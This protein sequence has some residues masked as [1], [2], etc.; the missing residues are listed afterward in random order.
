MFMFLMFIDGDWWT[1]LGRMNTKIA[2][3]NEMQAMSRP[4][5]RPIKLFTARE[6]ITCHALLIG[7]AMYIQ[8]GVNLWS[9]PNDTINGAPDVDEAWT[10]ILQGPNFDQYGVHCYR[11]KQ[12]KRFVPRMWESEELRVGQDRWWKFAEAINSFNE[13]RSENIMTSSN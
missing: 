6:F 5:Y 9:G 13:N 2:N 1:P 4:N 12:Y 10:S 7:S 3:F 11:F 8:R